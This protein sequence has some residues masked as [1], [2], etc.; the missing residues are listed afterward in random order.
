MKRGQINK[1]F[2][3][4]AII[5]SGFNLYRYYMSWSKPRLLPDFE[6]SNVRI[7]NNLELRTIV[8]Y[9]LKNNGSTT[10]DYVITAVS[11]IDG[12]DSLPFYFEKLSVGETVSIN[13]KIPLENYTKLKIGVN[14]LTFS[15]AK[16]YMVTPNLEPD[17]TT[18]PDFIIY[19]L[20]LTTFFKNNITVYNAV[21]SIM[22]IGGSPAH[23]VN[24]SVETASSIIMSVLPENEPSRVN[25]VLDSLS[26]EG[27]EVYIT[28]DEGVKQLYYLEKY[29]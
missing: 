19:N 12:N 29:D 17:V 9:E 14:C 24:I 13:R 11:P 1:V 6:V 22:N 3:I 7:L 4:I 15:E 28:C 10:A 27:I 2:L 18:I 20:S 25:M 21:F 5:L 23:K 16:Y 26:W 8:H